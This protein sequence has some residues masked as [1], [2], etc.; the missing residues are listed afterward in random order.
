MPGPAQPATVPAA[1]PKPSR[2][3]GLAR[4]AIAR[5]RG[6]GWFDTLFV[7]TVL[8]A[9]VIYL[10]VTSEFFFTSINLTNI[11]IQGAV[12]GIVAFG[13]TFVILAGELDLS[14]GS[15]LAL[16]S[17]VSAIVMRDSH[18]IVLGCLAAVGTGAGIGLINGLVV[19]RLEVPSFIATLGMLTIAHGLAL[20]LTNGSVIGGLPGGLNTIANGSF[21][22]VKW[23]VWIIVAVF[24]LAYLAQ[25]QTSFGI[26][27]FA[28]GGNREAARLSGIPVE[29]VRLL[30]FVIV[31]I[32]VGIAGIVLTARVESGQ[33][34]SGNLLALNAIAAIVVGG[35]NLLGGRGSV[36]RTLFGVLLIAV[37]TNGLQLKGVNDDLQQVIIGCVFIAAA[38]ADFVRNR[39]RRRRLRQEV[40]ADVEAPTA[41]PPPAGAVAQGAS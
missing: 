28:V 25:S 22:G 18:S 30:C 1:P 26:R 10:S 5:V 38:S 15:G 24:A 33:P 31:G 35:T 29:T 3:G 17:V 20:A 2:A 14:V 41:D 13:L 7:P 27:V 6:D 11:L 39:L 36:V 4:A 23:V 32:S 37:L 8:V 40:E 19:T 12:L 21:A 9:L 16:V 34:N